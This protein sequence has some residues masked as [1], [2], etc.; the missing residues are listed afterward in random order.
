VPDLLT[1]PGVMAAAGVMFAIEAVVDKVPYLDNTWD[2]LHTFVRP[3]VGGWLG[4]KFAGDA[5]ALDQAVAATGAGSTA[6]ASHAV[7]ASLRLVVNT[8]PEPASTIAVST[9]EDLAMAAMVA[10]IV[11]HPLEAAAVAAVLL[12]AGIALVLAIRRRVLRAVAAWRRRRAARGRGPRQAA[13]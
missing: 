2:L 11:T 12:A 13:E 1:N 4:L 9:L 10:L 6:L 7:K 8:S 5:A 3:V